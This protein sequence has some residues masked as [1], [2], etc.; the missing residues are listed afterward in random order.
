SFYA[1]REE[2][3]ATLGR[4]HQQNPL[5]PGMPKE[6]VKA[7]IRIDQKV[8]NHLVERVEEVV[9]DREM[10]RLRNFQVALSGVDASTKSR[11]VAAL[12]KEG[13]QPSSKSELAQKLSFSEKELNDLLRL[14][15]KEGALVRLNDSLY[16]TSPHHERM[17]KLLKDFFIHKGEMTVAEFRDLLGTTRKYAL[18]LLEYL[19]SHRITLRVGDVRKLMVK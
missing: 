14:L 11:I 4:F 18:P 12:E 3:Q 15:A 8:F 17:L 13:L 5:K 6:E 19:D 16:I 9:V 1:F 2:L 10:L 7:G